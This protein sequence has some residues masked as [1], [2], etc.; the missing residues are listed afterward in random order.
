MTNQNKNKIQKK[1]GVNPVVAAAAG[2]I[3]GAG[4]VA[5]GVVALND[6]KNREKVKEV[7]AN[8]KEQAKGYIEDIKK[9]EQAEKEEVEQNLAEGKEK[10]A[11][12]ATKAVDSLHHQAKEEIKAADNRV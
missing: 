11:E 3:V 12:V 9:K 2:V 10:V 6:E 7:L 1:D 8:V 4:V 5:A